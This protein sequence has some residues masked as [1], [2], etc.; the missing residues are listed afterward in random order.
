MDQKHG[1]SDNLLTFPKGLE[2]LPNIPRSTYRNYT[3]LGTI[4]RGEAGPT[5]QEMPKYKHLAN[6]LSMCYDRGGR[7]VGIIEEHLGESAF[8][9]FMRIVYSRYYFRVLRVADFQRELE[10]YTGRSWDDFFQH[11]LYGAGMSD[12]AVEDVKI[13]PA[14]RRRWLRRMVQPQAADCPCRATILLKQK[15]ENTEETF[16]GIRLKDGDGFQIRIPIQ[17]QIQHL[18][19]ED[20]TA[21]ID[22]LSENCARVVVELPCQPIQIT[23]DPDQILIDADPTNN[24]WR[25]EIRWRVVPL[26][27]QL[28]ETDLTTAYDRW[29]IIVG[30]WIYGPSYKDPW[31]T[32][33]T[34]AGLRAGLYRTQEF[35]GGAY[36]AYR[37]DDRDLV[38]GVD[39]LWSHWP[40]HS[41]EVGFNIERSVATVGADQPPSDRG[42]LFGR[43]VFQYSS[44]LYLPPMEYLEAFTAI[45]NNNLPPPT[46]PIPGAV[47]INDSTTI[48]LHYHKDYLTPYWDPE[49][50]F[51]L[52]LTYA[53]GIPIFGEQEAFNAAEGQFSFVK[54]LPDWMG[55]LS[56]TRVAGRIFAGIGLPNNG[57]Y[58]TLGGGDLF[59]GFDLKQRQGSL[60]WVGSLEWRVPL[61][62][63]LQCDVVDHSAGLRGI[64][65]APFYDVGN[66]Y[67]NGHAEGDVAQAL[68]IGLRLD[69]A[70]FGFV[71]RTVLRVDVAK[72]I[73]SNS[74]VQVWVGVQ[75]PF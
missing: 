46:T 71:E 57:E 1:K 6:L 73:N 43:Y 55:W 35:S 4:G 63:G 16:L 31:F 9:D 56:E 30:P 50:G 18:D 60:V 20:P 29:N 68:G 15:A 72:T 5:V 66:A 58:F 27:T 28:E 54:T 62:R 12:W 37:T 65:V 3:M 40:W 26:Y 44:S 23:V 38:V 25:P 34:M 10:E 61:A 49:A 17:P 67:V 2:W 53:T 59:R 42:V 19:L 13:E 21:T 74:P 32:R 70:W 52:D 64:Y 45:Q 48:G 14:Q 39:G 22:F 24:N 33:S 75:Q 7:I 8:F 51:R 36:T 69:V 11:W 47:P 41:T